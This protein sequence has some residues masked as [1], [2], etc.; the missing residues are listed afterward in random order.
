MQQ[1]ACVKM[2]EW[3][4]WLENTII[5]VTLA[6]FNKLSPIFSFQN[7]ITSIYTQI[8]VHEESTY[9]QTLTFLSVI[10]FKK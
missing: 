9:E 5:L 4:I 7:K 3:T 8:T 2:S 10:M 1:V 6:F